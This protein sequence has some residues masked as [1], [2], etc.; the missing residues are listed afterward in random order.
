MSKR[1]YRKTAG[2]MSAHIMLMEKERRPAKVYARYRSQRPAVHPLYHIPI[3]PVNHTQLVE[4]ESKPGFVS[5]F[6]YE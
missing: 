4:A 3:T 5:F 1:V 2:E 6:I